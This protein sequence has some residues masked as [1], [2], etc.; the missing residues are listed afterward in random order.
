M[1][2]RYRSSRLLAL[3]LFSVAISCL[4]VVCWVNH[5]FSQDGRHAPSTEVLLSTTTQRTQKLSD[6]ITAPIQIF[7]DALKS[8]LRA[9]EQP[10]TNSRPGGD[11]QE[12]WV[13]PDLSSLVLHKAGESAQ[14]GLL[15]AHRW[16]DNGD[17]EFRVVSVGPQTTNGTWMKLPF[18]LTCIVCPFK[19]HTI[20]A[21]RHACLYCA[22]CAS[23][24]VYHSVANDIALVT[25]VLD[26]NACAHTPPHALHKS[27]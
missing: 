14:S 18:R 16:Q 26:V 13:I 5:D 20:F 7:S 17:K 4:A 12:E 1:T 6:F 19:M 15:H 3:G 8:S 10:S 9:A 21:H 27:I 22:F 2:Y 25:V 11:Q 24:Y 23:V